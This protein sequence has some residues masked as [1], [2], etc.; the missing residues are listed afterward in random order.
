MR[1]HKGGGG[2]LV[3]ADVREGGREG[4]PPPSLFGRVCQAASRR[5]REGGF[6]KAVGSRE[7]R[8]WGRSRS[9]DGKAKGGGKCETEV[10]I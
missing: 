2:D 9:L 1:Q 5:R 6:E 3:A 4:R 7:R 10:R 8:G